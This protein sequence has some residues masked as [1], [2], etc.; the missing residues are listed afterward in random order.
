[1]ELKKTMKAVV[2][3]EEGKLV[4]KDVP[5][6]VPSEGRVLIKVAAAAQN[7]TDRTRS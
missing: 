1:M 3:A 5:V 4:V 6:P 2:V 7:P